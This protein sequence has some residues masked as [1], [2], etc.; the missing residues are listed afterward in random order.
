MGDCNPRLVVIKTNPYAKWQ[1]KFVRA[2][3]METNHS[4]MNRNSALLRRI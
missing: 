2:S 4:F 1:L 3:T